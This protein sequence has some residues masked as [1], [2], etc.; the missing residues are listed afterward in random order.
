MTEVIPTEFKLLGC[1]V[2]VGLVQLGL[3][4]G[5]ANSQRSMAWGLGPRDEPWPLTGV[6]G[7]MQRAFAN[8]AETFPLFA[9]AVIAADLT[10][11]LG[12]Q[13]LVGASL[14]LVGRVLFV[15]A[16]ALGLAPWRT[17]AWA[18]SV[19]GIVMV[20]VALFQ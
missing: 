1:A 19:V 18:I 15:P 20:T 14:Y 4:A 16:Y 7:R 3:A 13:T 17:V 2:I 11:R 12:S 9:A 8:F 6:A 5:L 10:H